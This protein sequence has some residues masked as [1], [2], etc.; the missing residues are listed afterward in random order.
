MKLCGLVDREANQDCF[1]K[2]LLSTS[3][4]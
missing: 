2:H 1:L 4:R 3:S